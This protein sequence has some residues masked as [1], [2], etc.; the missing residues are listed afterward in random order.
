[1]EIPNTVKEN[2][3]K[4]GGIK[5]LSDAT[6]R[7]E[8]LRPVSSILQSVS[9]PVRLSV[10]YSLS[11]A[12]LCVCVMK[13]MLRIADSKLSYHLSRLRETGLITQ[14]YEGKFIVYEI[15]DLGSRLLS[16]INNIEHAHRKPT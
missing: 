3:D 14:R 1:M 12:P 7:K 2:L 4:V 16:A 6:P 13:S 5:A 8:R 10:L 9:D 15:T 11:T